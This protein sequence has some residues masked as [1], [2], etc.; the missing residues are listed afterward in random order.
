MIRRGN[1]RYQTHIDKICRHFYT[2]ASIMP[3]NPFHHSVSVPD[4][5]SQP[6]HD[7]RGSYTERKRAASDECPNIAGRMN[8]RRLQLDS[9]HSGPHT[10]HF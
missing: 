1:D 9:Q 4:N 8:L 2:S 7:D 3:G 10:T 5:P 6:G